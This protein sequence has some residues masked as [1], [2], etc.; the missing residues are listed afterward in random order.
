M[1]SPLSTIRNVARAPWTPNSRP[2]SAVNGASPMSRTVSS[3]LSYSTPPTPPSKPASQTAVL[4]R[5]PVA[6]SSGR[7][8]STLK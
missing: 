1:N 5:Y 4:R 6:I 8:M 3:G 7:R 2:A